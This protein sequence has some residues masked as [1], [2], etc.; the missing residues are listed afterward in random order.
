MEIRINDRTID[1]V[2]EDRTIVKISINKGVASYLKDIEND[3]N[4]PVTITWYRHCGEREALKLKDMAFREMLKFVNKVCYKRADALVIVFPKTEL[5]AQ[6]AVLV[7]GFEFLRN[8][9]DALVFIK[10]I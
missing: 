3:Y 2:Y 1:F 6:A 8:E 9:D 10:K 4:N 7:D 5:I